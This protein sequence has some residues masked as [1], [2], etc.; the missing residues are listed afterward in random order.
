MGARFNGFATRCNYYVRI[1]GYDDKHE[2]YRIVDECVRDLCQ[3][4]EAVL[5]E[6]SAFLRLSRFHDRYQL[7]PRN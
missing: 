5:N 1:D 2:I 6:D 4:S 7:M 3:N